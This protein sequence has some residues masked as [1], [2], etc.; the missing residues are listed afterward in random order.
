MDGPP[1]SVHTIA[2]DFILFLLHSPGVPKV[3]L[4]YKNLF[5]AAQLHNR[6]QIRLFML[7]TV[8]FQA[9]LRTLLHSLALLIEILD[10]ILPGNNSDK[11]LLVVQNRYKVLCA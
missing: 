5:L 9:L 4:L 3:F 6:R 8:L 7:C 11:A 10:N 2:V 1:V